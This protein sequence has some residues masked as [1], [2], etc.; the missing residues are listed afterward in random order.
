MTLG[1]QI[2]SAR[3]AKNLSQE[4]LAEHLG[5]SRQAVSKWENGT[6]V[7]QGVNMAALIE[8]L[9][10][11]VK[12][13]ESAP[14]TRGISVWLGWAIAGVLLIALVGVLIWQSTKA[15]DTLIFPV[16]QP[17]EP[18]TTPV[19]TAPPEDAEDTPRV[20]SIR[21]YDSE[22][23]EVHAEALWYNTARIESILIQWTG[24]LPLES[25]EMYFTPQGTETSEQTELLKTKYVSNNSGALLLS[26]DSLHREGLM[27]YLFFELHFSQNCTIQSGQQINVVYDSSATSL[28]Y[29]LSLD[30]AVLTCDRVE[31]ILYPS[32]RA[33]EL[34]LV[35][36]G[37]GFV[38][39][40]EHETPLPFPVADNCVY[41]VLD[42][43]NNYTPMEVSSAEFQT[44]LVARSGTQIP[45]HLTFSDGW[46]VEISEQYLP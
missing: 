34:D 30:R 41:T 3:E 43:S 14:K 13:D 21:F 37:N 22:Q 29:I 40:N 23:N 28:A 26:A 1:E 9:E 42:W 33:E 35:D 45:Y 12:K 7:P 5:V 24:D 6:A 32:V 11:D 25:V 36:P 46:I 16:D 17:A 31:W 2:R 44:L 10:L 4:A 27:G 39:Y 20:T 15:Q 38:V 8:I 19:E 18:E